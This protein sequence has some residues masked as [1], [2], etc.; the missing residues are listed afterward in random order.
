MTPTRDNLSQGEF[1]ALIA[2]LF[3]TVALSIDAMLPALPEIATTLSPE[4]PNRAQLVVTSFVLGMGLGTLF[5][6][7]L[8]DA[9]GRKRIILFGS[10]LYCL[11]ALAC[12]FA[13]TLEMLLA[14]RVVQG[15]GSAG[16]RTVSIAL[17]RDLFKGREMARIMSFAMM[18]FTLV[19]ALAPL[20]GQGVMALTSWHAIFLVYIGFAGVTMAWLGLRQPETLP[21]AARRPLSVGALLTATREL[22]A[23]RIVVLSILCQSL[24]LGALFSTL[25]S[26]QGI[27]EQRFDRADQFPLW[28]ALIAA[29][30]ASGSL[31]N[32]RAVMRF[33]M[34][35]MVSA[36][37]ATV[38]GLTLAHLALV[39]FGLMPEALAFPAFIAWGVALFAMMGLTLGNLNALAM[40]PVGHIAGLAASV[41]SALATVGSVLLAVPVGQAFD[42]TL[43]PLLAGVSIFIAASLAL[44]RRA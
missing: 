12:F 42:G 5:A 11:A 44:I 36:T 38:L 24:T 19:P 15:I 27:F 6:G 1:I 39:A 4:A 13:P 33:G 32:A 21:R 2:M 16:P 18:V 34:R 10:A 41:I 14:A 30:S 23:H 31:L 22:F 17:V 9:F 40:E 43:V 26:I 8:S 35:R 28:F 29:L 7:P 20:M 3:A 25:S 37:Y